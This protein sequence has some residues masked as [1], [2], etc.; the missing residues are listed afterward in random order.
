MNKVKS[1]YKDD[2]IPYGIEKPN[3]VSQFETSYEIGS[4]ICKLNFDK[5]NYILNTSN[6]NP[7]IEFNLS[8]N[9]L[10]VMVFVILI[11]ILVI[12]QLIL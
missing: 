1:I 12:Y 5:N 9:D 2:C 3:L 11:L 7:F 10:M 8:E 6:N 4:Y